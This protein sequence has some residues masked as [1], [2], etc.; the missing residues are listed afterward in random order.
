MRV[1]V[2]Y[3]HNRLPHKLVQSGMTGVYALHHVAPGVSGM[4]LKK[5]RLKWLTVGPAD[6]RML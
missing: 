5:A 6:G 2:P 1:A 3:R 4:R